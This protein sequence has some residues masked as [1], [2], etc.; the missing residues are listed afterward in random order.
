MAAALKRKHVNGKGLSRCFLSGIYSSPSWLS[1]LGWHRLT[2]AVSVMVGWIGQY[3]TLN[4][5]TA[6]FILSSSV[7]PWICYH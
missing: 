4:E 1:Q 7:C 3:L 2:W 5:N 6:I